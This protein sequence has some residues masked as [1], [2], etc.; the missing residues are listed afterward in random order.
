[1]SMTYVKTLICTYQ[2]L[3]EKIFPAHVIAKNNVSVSFDSNNW[4]MIS[5]TISNKYATFLIFSRVTV[6]RQEHAYCKVGQS[7]D[8]SFIISTI[9][10]TLVSKAFIVITW[11]R[12]EKIEKKI[13][14]SQKNSQNNDNL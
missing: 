4:D 8:V 11:T 6:K 7:V 3:L 1:M 12:S 14:K 5:I 13:L 10:F 9:T 2:L